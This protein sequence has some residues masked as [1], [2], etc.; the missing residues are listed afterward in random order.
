MLFNIRYKTIAVIGI[1]IIINKSR[2]P[3]ALRSTI[4][5]IVIDGINPIFIISKKSTF[6]FIKKVKDNRKNSN[7]KKISKQTI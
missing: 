4:D 1:T 5:V 7:I 2:F 3:K 6:F